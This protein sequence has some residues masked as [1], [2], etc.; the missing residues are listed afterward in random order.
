MILL[1]A[2]ALVALLAGERSAAR[3]DA[4]LRSGEAAIQ[5]VSLAEVLDVTVRVRGHDMDAVQ[6]VLV[7]LVETALPVVPVGELEA[8]LGAA[9]RI[10]HYHR[11]EAPLSLVDCLLIGSALALDAEIA[12]SDVLLAGIARLEGAEVVP[13]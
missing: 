1:D 5:A 4:L 8:R 10:A 9:V 12:T 13:L 7:P 11:R 6:A 2:S 3:V